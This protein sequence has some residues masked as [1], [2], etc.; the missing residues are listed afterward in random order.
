[1]SKTTDDISAQANALSPTEKLELVD[2]IVASLDDSDPTLD[3]LW[4]REAE[5]R[6][7]AY[8]RGEVQAISLTDALAH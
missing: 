5:Q 6:L 7:A 8:R 3:S 1:M 2:R 4:L